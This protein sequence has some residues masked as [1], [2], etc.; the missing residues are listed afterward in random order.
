MN[1]EVWLKGSKLVNDLQLRETGREQQNDIVKERERERK[2]ILCHQPHTTIL[3]MLRGQSIDE[4]TTQTREGE[5]RG[6]ENKI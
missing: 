2:S 6:M 1:V 4:P 5:E 3:S